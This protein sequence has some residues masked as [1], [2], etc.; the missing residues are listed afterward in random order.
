MI[1]ERIEF[2]LELLEPELTAAGW[3]ESE[4][5][6]HPKGTPVEGGRFAPKG[7]D[8]FISEP[9]DWS[10]VLAAQGQMERLWREQ[11]ARAASENGVERGWDDAIQAK[12]LVQ[13]SIAAKLKGDADFKSLYKALDPHGDWEAEF[14]PGGSMLTAKTREQKI[15]ALAVK[16][17]STTA[18]DGDPVALQFQM[19]AEQEFGLEP[20][21]YVRQA[22]QRYLDGMAET[23]GKMDFD[24]LTISQ[25]ANA[26]I[27]TEQQM[28]GARKFLRAQYE[29]TQKM[30]KDAGIT[31]VYGYRGMRFD[32]VGTRTP[33][34]QE[35]RDSLESA[36]A[37]FSADDEAWMAEARKDSSDANLT[38][39]GR[40][41]RFQDYAGQ[42][43]MSIHQNPLSSWA[44]D[45]NT[46]ET[47]ASGGAIG[48]VAGT[49]IDV[50]RI[51]STPFTGFG[52]LDENEMVVL[53]GEDMDAMVWSWDSDNWRPASD[54]EFHDQWEAAASRDY[55]RR[56]EARRAAT[57]G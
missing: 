18:S 39:L 33:P 12:I 3:D 56:K 27:F 44:H 37:R 10:A 36:K 57:G 42:D 26:Q 21:T 38:R 11:A 8:V 25:K 20:S 29:L 51:L 31:E 32:G 34:P 16:N 6:R 47:F 52:C 4:H 1:R 15:A 41:P 40:A 45:F 22:W 17:W 2:P 13:N 48:A 53:G 7:E 55:E 14:G 49:R 23:Y 24:E 30:F 28:A 19:A 5:P 43:I 9:E 46:A 54:G 35:I 50:R